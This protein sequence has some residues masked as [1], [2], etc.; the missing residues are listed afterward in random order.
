MTKLDGTATPPRPARAE[1]PLLG[2]SLTVEPRTLTPLVLV[3]IQVPQPLGLQNPRTDRRFSPERTV[4]RSLRD[5]TMGPSDGALARR[6]AERAPK[7]QA[8]ARRP[9]RAPRRRMARAREAPEGACGRQTSGEPSNHDRRRALC[10]RRP[11]GAGGACGGRSPVCGGERNERGADRK[12]A[13]CLARGDEADGGGEPRGD[14]A[15]VP[16]ARGVHR[17]GCRQRPREECA[18]RALPGARP[19]DA[20]RGRRVLGRGS[21]QARARRFRVRT[22]GARAGAG[23]RSARARLR[24]A[25]GAGGRERLDPA[26][27]QGMAP[28][29]ARAGT[30]RRG[31]PGRARSRAF[32]RP[33]AGACAGLRR[34]S[35]GRRRLHGHAS[36]GDAGLPGDWRRRRSAAR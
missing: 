15:H 21:R 1:R 7:A 20:G 10:G 24:D 22:R 18:G 19:V 28:V 13:C 26:R 11:R 34:R 35:K 5:H 23:G 6:S 33:P 31:R 9:P 16:H 3:R 14:R 8:R 36:G 2:D 27:L 30:V 29:A 32:A 25:R 12:A 17:D 4:G